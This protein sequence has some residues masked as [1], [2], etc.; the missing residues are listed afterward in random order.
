[1]QRLGHL[2]AIAPFLLAPS[3]ALADTLENALTAAYENNPNMEEARLAVR[4]A[5]QD[6][7][8]ARAGYLPSLTVGGSYGIQ[9]LEVE[10]TSIFGPSTSETELNPSTTSVELSQSLF[11][12]WRRLGASRL[13]R[14]SVDN[15]RETLRATEQDVLLAT[16]D[17]YLNVRRDEEIVRLNEAHVIGLLRQLAGTNRRLEVG[18]VSRTDVAQAET[19]LAGAR[20][21]LARAQAELERTRARYEEIVGLPPE[22]LEPVETLP[23]AP[24]SLDD[25]LELALASHPDLGR[26][27]ANEG[28]ARARVTIERAALLPQV[29]VVGRY[30]RS[31]ESSFENDRRE[32]P[33]ALARFS[34]PIFEGG[35][36]WSR[37]HQ[38]RLNVRRAEALTEAQ[39]RQIS[40]NVIGAWNDVIAAR[41]VLEAAS[42]QVRASQVALAGAERERGLGM[43]S[44]LDVLDA[45]EEA[46]NA[47]VNQARAE[48]NAVLAVFVLAA[49]TGQ[50]S[51]A[52]VAGEA[53]E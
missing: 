21:S 40:A 45:E 1:M 16:V 22:A 30:D 15:A 3:A 33:S 29:S 39:R 41:D 27:R 23:A 20:A 35:L 13:A 32:G 25:A 31:E 24:A 51:L 14:A 46:R 48:A 36:A 5:R 9:E 42:E 12:G 37:A 10:S 47:R 49:A 19:R 38:S 18:E 44:T 52:E 43:R 6:R 4:S 17:A 28:A 8:Q 2:M 50:L 11:T 7:V 26:A 53:E 34:M